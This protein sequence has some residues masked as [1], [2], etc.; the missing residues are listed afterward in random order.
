MFLL[1]FL[2]IPYFLPVV[3]PKS[4]ENYRELVFSRKIYCSTNLTMQYFSMYTKIH[5]GITIKPCVCKLLSVTGQW[6]NDKKCMLFILG[7]QV[8]RL[9]SKYTM[10]AKSKTLKSITI[11]IVN[12]DNWHM[13]AIR[14]NDRFV[15][16]SHFGAPGHVSIQNI[17][18]RN[19]A[20][21]T[22]PQNSNLRTSV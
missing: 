2:D 13:S 20:A 3:Y 21:I 12:N 9:R 15:F 17:F 10:L 1:C 5:F 6:C 8:N 16:W 14:C 11:A 7:G 19:Q 18:Y 22:T 4:F